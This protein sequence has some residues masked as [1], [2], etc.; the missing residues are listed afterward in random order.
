MA[1]PNTAVPQKP[2]DSNA[3]HKKSKKL[4]KQFED[5]FVQMEQILVKL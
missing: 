2:Y 1:T 3:S 5:L 4:K